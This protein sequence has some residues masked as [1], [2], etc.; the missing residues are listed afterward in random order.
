MNLDEQKKHL[1]SKL[2]QLRS[3]ESADNRKLMSQQIINNL[4]KLDE[5]KHA[6]NVFCY[7]SYLSE[8]NTFPLIKHFLEN[9]ANLTVPKIIG[10]TEMIAVQIADLASLE[11]DKM[12]IL[13]P[14]S[15]QSFTGSFDIVI[16]PGL[17][18]NP[19]GNRLGYGRGYYDR[20]FTKNTVCSKIGLAFECQ[21]LESL[22]T[23]ETDIPIDILVSEK[24]VIKIAEKN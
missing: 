7:V 5:F 3:N 13:T 20:W 4:H 1:R 8:V 17:A 11:P 2:K 24:R 9:G 15:N 12:G 23:E 21:I 18:F 16:T 22:P 10:K 14:K 19:A 6:D